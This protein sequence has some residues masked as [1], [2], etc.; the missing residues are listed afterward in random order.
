MS[1]EKLPWVLRTNIY[2]V[3]LRQYTEAGNFA[4]FRT[5]MPR[6]RDMGVHTL[7]FMPIT[8]I[9]VLKR[10]GTMGSYYACSDYLSVN[11]EFG[12]EEEFR[13]LVVYAHELGMKVIIDWVA[14]HTGAGHTW[15][16]TNPDFFIRDGEGQFYDKHGWEDVI[17]LDYTNAQMRGEM[18]RSMEYWV[19]ECD[20]DGFRCDMAMLVPLDFWMEARTHLDRVKNLFWL[21]ECD[22]WNDPDYL[23]V[24]DASYTWKWMHTAHEYMLYH[25]PIETLKEVLYGYSM[26]QPTDSVKAWFTSNHDENSWNG[27]EYEKY[28]NM[29]I[30]LAVFSC[31]WNGIPLLYSGQ[32]LP[33]TKRLAFFEK[34]PIEW[35]HEP[36][37]HEFYK[38]LLNLKFEHPALMA[39]LQGGTTQYLNTDHTDKVLCFVRRSGSAEVVV[40]L[41][42]SEWPLD[43]KLYDHIDLARYD[44]IFGVQTISHNYPYT[45]LLPAWGFGVWAK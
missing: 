12:T 4:A 32:E 20:I 33:N 44:E 23:R 37:L 2:E 24:F 17:D 29:A 6:L 42:L 45:V 35:N 38:K 40:M 22:Q 15:T 41:N 3:N 36:R 5:H 39:T 7:W 21:A 26:L 19:R 11:P 10:K 1:F 31:L 8:P 30:P 27:T 9:S 13:E 28:G 34:D 16:T 25:K 43:V 18:I 14:N